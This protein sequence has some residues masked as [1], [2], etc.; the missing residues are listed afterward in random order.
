MVDVDSW[1]LV[2]NFSDFGARLECKESDERIYIP[3]LFEAGA[4]PWKFRDKNLDR[5]AAMVKELVKHVGVVTGDAATMPGRPRKADS[6]QLE[7]A[8]QVLPRKAAVRRRTRRSGAA[9]TQVQSRD[10]DMEDTE[11]LQDMPDDTQQA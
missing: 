5:N 10:V 11:E 6:G 4:G 8:S 9:A 3:D 1:E 2:D 7:E